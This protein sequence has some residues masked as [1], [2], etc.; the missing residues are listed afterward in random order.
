VACPLSVLSNW[1]K[2][3]QKFAPLVPVSP[4]CMSTLRIP[5]DLSGLYNRS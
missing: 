4:V 5:A 2:E 3:F 1:I